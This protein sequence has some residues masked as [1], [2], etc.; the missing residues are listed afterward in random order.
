MAER[1]AP[2]PEREYSYKTERTSPFPA[3]P[4]YRMVAGGVSIQNGV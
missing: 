2:S 1:Q 4:I 3:Q